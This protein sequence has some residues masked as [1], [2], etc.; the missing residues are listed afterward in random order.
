MRA[1]HPIH[2][3]GDQS[4]K[5]IADESIATNRSETELDI[6]QESKIPSFN[7]KTDEAKETLHT[8][9]SLVRSSLPARVRRSSAKS[10]VNIRNLN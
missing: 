8:R 7:G 5:P 2:H 9:N 1:L 6:A 10:M 4:I 3:K